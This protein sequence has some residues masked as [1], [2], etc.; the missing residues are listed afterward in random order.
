MSVVRNGHLFV[1]LHGFADMIRALFPLKAPRRR[2]QQSALLFP[3][4]TATAH[5]TVSNACAMLLQ[6]VQAMYAL[7]TGADQDIFC[8]YLLSYPAPARL[9]ITQSQACASLDALE[10]ELQSAKFYARRMCFADHMVFDCSA[11]ESHRW[12]HPS[13][14]KRRTS[15]SLS[16]FM[17]Q[18]PTEVAAY[19]SECKQSCLALADG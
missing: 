13:L 16:A 3:S 1:D 12:N 15:R 9:F 19:V 8:A 11:L 10:A 7:S 4:L 2:P 17:D 14:F 18:D 5:R 6:A